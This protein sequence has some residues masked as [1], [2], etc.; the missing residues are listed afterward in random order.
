MQNLS[1]EDKNK[2]FIID[3][4]PPT[5]SGQLHMGH[6]FSYSHADFIARYKR[7]KN[8]K[9]IYPIGF[10]DNGLPTEKLVEKQKGIKGSTYEKEGKKEEFL[11]ECQTVIDEAEIEFEKLFKTLGYSYNWNLKYQTISPSSALIAQWSF[12]DLVD[13]KLIEQKYAPVYWDIIDQTALANAEIEEVEQDSN[14]CYFKFKLCDKDGNE[15]GEVIEIMTTRPEMLPA[16]LAVM[17]SP[18]HQNASNFKGKYA[19]IPL[20]NLIVKLIEDET[21]SIEKGTGAMMVCS[22]GDWHDVELI[23][24]HSKTLI[25]FQNSPILEITE[26]IKSNGTIKILETEYKNPKQAHEAVIKYC[27]ENNLFSQPKVLIK[28]MVKVGERSKYP[29]EIIETSQFYLKLKDFKEDFLEISKHINFYPS[30]MKHRLEQWINSIDRDW[31]ISRDRFMGIV[32]PFENKTFTIEKEVDL[33]KVSDLLQK[34]ENYRANLSQTH[35]AY[36]NRYTDREIIIIPNDI[37]NYPYNSGQKF[38]NKD[39]TE[40]TIQS[41]QVFDTWFTS[42]CSPQL[43]ARYLN[44]NFDDGRKFNLPFQMRTQSHEIIRTWCFYTIVKAY[45]HGLTKEELEER[46]QF[47]NTGKT[48][49]DWFKHKQFDKFETV[50][51]RALIP[52]ENV[53]LS[54]WCLASDKTKMSKS[55]GNIITPQSLIEEKGI[56]TIRYWAASSHLGVDTPYNETKFV[57]AKR[58]LNKLENAYKFCIMTK[59][60]YNNYNNLLPSEIF[61]VN[62]VTEEFDKWILFKFFKTLK[63]YENEMDIFEYAK[64]KE[65]AEKFFWQDFCDNY[66]EIIKVRAYGLGA[67]I[68]QAKT[69]SQLEKDEVLKKQR[70]AL[71]TLLILL[72]GILKLFAPFLINK[73]EELYN[74]FTKEFNLEE[75]SIHS[76]GN[77]IHESN[78]IQTFSNLENCE[79]AIELIAFVRKEKSEQKLSMKAE[80]SSLQI[81]F[82]LPKE[83]EFDTRAVCNAFDAEIQIKEEENLKVEFI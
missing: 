24:K 60:N 20:T 40:A 45:L 69:L 76:Q 50:K 77:W 63:N 37:K 19:K 30:H 18:Q 75:K 82:Q 9:V 79:K 58:L 55:K 29:L 23:Q 25:D 33:S 67:F 1:S 78:L 7:M 53:V 48:L 35:S 16:C 2:K 81:N 3:T 26:N 8:F 6:V 31:C 10:D 39:E 14:Q 80:I 64:A 32:I 51:N 56:D 36:R 61:N 65:L 38:K 83:L 47:L 66:L 74:Q 49:Q 21:I 59:T 17:Y 34:N 68:F 62:V 70:S 46:E 41:K 43:V 72:D 73:C 57:D 54:G 28:Q 71:A 52:W 15:N 13:K 42:S 11:K 27:E 22:Y 5:V 12:K 4:P 44:E